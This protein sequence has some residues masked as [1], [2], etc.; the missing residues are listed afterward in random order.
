MDIGAA[1]LLSPLVLAVSATL[2]AQGAAIAKRSGHTYKHWTAVVIGWAVLSIVP[3]VI[4]TVIL[5]TW[6]EGAYDT[7]TSYHH[8]DSGDHVRFACWVF[9][10]LV[11]MCLPVLVASLKGPDG[12]KRN[13]RIRRNGS[14]AR[15]RA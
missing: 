10:G 15:R 5:M 1:I 9:G 2:N 11:F 8:L 13:R 3:A 12:S 6:N 4:V 7:F 14:H